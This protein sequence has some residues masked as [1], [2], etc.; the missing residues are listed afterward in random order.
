MLSREFLL[1]A[2]LAALAFGCADDADEA[3][4]ERTPVSPEGGAAA[5]H[6]ED[7]GT[8]DSGVDAGADSSEGGG[9][10]ACELDERGACPEGCQ[11]LR[12]RALDGESQCWQEAIVLGC[13]DD[14]IVFAPALG[15]YVDT[16]S[17]TL[18]IT[19]SLYSLDHFEDYRVCDDDEQARAMALELDRGCP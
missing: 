17:E 12:G 2:A 11:P 18:Y 19:N 9:P 3:S 10:P 5:D 7:A 8:N 4:V 13:A 14:D 16:A 6:R 1:S 15:C